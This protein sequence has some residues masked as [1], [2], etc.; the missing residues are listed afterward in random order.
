MISVTLKKLF[1]KRHNKSLR[2]LASRSVSRLSQL[3]KNWSLYFYQLMIKYFIQKYYKKNNISPLG[4]LKEDINNRNEKALRYIDYAIKN[5][6]N[7]VGI[8]DKLR[9]IALIKKS[10][11]EGE[12]IYHN[13]IMELHDM[14]FVHNV[15]KLNILEVDS[16][17]NDILSP[18][19]KIERSC[20]IKAC[21]ATDTYYFESK[22]A[23]SEIMTVYQK[24][25]GEYFTPTDDNKIE[26]WIANKSKE[27]DEKGANYLICRVPVWV[28]DV[29]QQEKEF[30]DKWAER[31]FKN[32]FTIK[33]KTS[34]NET[35]I[36]P[37]IQLSSDF[38]GIYVI[39]EFGYLKFGD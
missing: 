14:F 3:I 19:R 23:S 37:R 27:A 25:G 11:N 5:L 31:I 8:K 26:R 38:K 15:L 21:D 17:T 9:E 20:D 13:S 24:N 16:R 2:N 4:R 34:K 22:D 6:L 10:G 39:K 35:I 18:Y 1:E 12:R 32:S 28:Y 30:Y 36:S 33:S 7:V 29:Y